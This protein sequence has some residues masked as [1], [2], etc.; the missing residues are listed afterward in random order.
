[1]L[2]FLGMSSDGSVGVEHHSEVAADCSGWEIFC[3]FSSNGAGVSV[4]LH[5][6]T[7]NALEVGTVL[8]V[9]RSVNVSNTLSE[10]ECTRLAVV[11]T[12]NFNESL[13]FMLRSL[14]AFKAHKSCLLVQSMQIAV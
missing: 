9:L 6:F 8:S 11:N 7:P 14:C 3:E 5:D 13:L 4:S 10:V 12:L 1:M 2:A